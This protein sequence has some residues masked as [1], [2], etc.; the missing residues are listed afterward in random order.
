MMTAVEIFSSSVY[1][2][3]KSRICSIN[4]VVVLFLR[5]L[6][7]LTP[8]FIIYNAGGFSL[9]NRLYTEKPDV[10]FNYKY[11][12]LANKNYNQN[13]VVC[14]TFTTY[15]NNE[16]K[17]NCV[18]IKVQE[19]DTNSDGKKDILKFEAHFYTDEPIRS[20]KLLLF[21]NFQLKRLFEANIESIALFSNT[22]DGEVQNVVF[23]GDLILEQKG[24]LTSEGLYETY[25]HSLELGDRSLD[26]LLLQS[27]NRKFAV[28]ISNEYVTKQLGDLNESAVIVK[29]ELIYREYLIYYQPSFWEELKWAWVQ[30]LSCFLVFAYLTKHILIFLF[31]NR[32]L[33]SYVVLPWKYTRRAMSTRSK[34]KVVAAFRKLFRSSEKIS[35]Q[36]GASSSTSSP[37]RRLLSRHHRPDAVTPADGSDNLGAGNSNHGSCFFKTK[38]STG[39]STQGTGQA[40]VPDKRVNLRRL[41]KELSEIQKTQHRRESTFTAELVNDN[42]FEWHVR[43]HKIDPESEL[44]ADMRELNIPYIL[45]HVVFPENF[46]FAPPF[47]RVISPR[48][49]KGFVMEGGAICM[50]LL[51]PRGWAS[52]YTIEAVITQFAASIVKGQGRVTRKPK[53]K[54]DV[55]FN[56]RSAEESFRSLVKTHEK[57]GWVTPPLAEG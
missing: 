20:L 50:E 33:N 16:I 39:S 5:I 43:L 14:S 26:E 31:S 29:A 22:L 41:M 21:F 11:L 44:A 23:Y 18:L 57:Y 6:S 25:N 40:G 15:K 34:E 36:D 35:E 48:I 47:M 7:L 56:R 55:P 1:F 54:K 4:F 45:L 51:T 9:K 28:K 19:I 8:F 46:P 3:Y 12:L 17:D 42:L 24:L 10:S 32:Y 37:S 38:K 27:F 53:T 52:A 49:E 13:P 30:Y 2:K